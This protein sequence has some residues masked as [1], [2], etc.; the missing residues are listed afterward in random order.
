MSGKPQPHTANPVRRI[1][2]FLNKVKKPRGQD[3]CW[4]WSATKINSGY[5]HFW[6]GR[7]LV[8][9]HRFLY[10]FLNGPVT[11]KLELDHIVCSRRDCVRPDHLRP[12]SHTENMRRAVSGEQ[13]PR[14]KLRRSDVAV[15]RAQV[16]AGSTHQSVAKGFSVSRSLVGQ[17]VNNLIWRD[18][19]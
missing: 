13:N 11:P 6:N 4:I 15:I 16:A 1:R 19:L 10:E 3:G 2:L 9:A 7:K 5:G 12:V 14:A 8:L 18:V 17:I